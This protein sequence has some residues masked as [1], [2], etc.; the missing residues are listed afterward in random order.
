MEK[1]KIFSALEETGEPTTSEDTLSGRSFIYD[2]N[3]RGPRTV[4][5]GTPEITGELEDDWPSMMTFCWRE[6]RKLSIY[7]LVFPRMPR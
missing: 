2:K 7:N 1:K 6:V 5:W 3:N 4:P